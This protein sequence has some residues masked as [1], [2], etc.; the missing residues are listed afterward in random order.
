MRIEALIPDLPQLREAN[1]SPS[2]AVRL[3]AGDLPDLEAGMQIPATV[4]QVRGSR[5]PSSI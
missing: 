4:L 2:Q 3:L 1:L 5:R